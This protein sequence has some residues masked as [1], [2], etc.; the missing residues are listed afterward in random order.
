MGKRRDEG[1]GGGREGEA[2]RREA[3]NRAAARQREPSQMVLDPPGKSTSSQEA[4]VV[5]R[6]RRT[7]AL[8]PRHTATVPPHELLPRPLLFPLLTRASLAHCHPRASLHVPS[9][10]RS[11][12]GSVWKSAYGPPPLPEVPFPPP[13]SHRPRAVFPRPPRM[14]LAPSPS[15]SAPPPRRRRPT[16]APAVIMTAV[17][18]AMAARPRHGRG[19]PP[20]RRP[21][22]LVEGIVSATGTGIR[23]KGEAEQRIVKTK[24]GAQQREMCVGAGDVG[25]RGG[26]DA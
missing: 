14:K 9:F 20:A 15:P 16:T 23:L 6:T 11:P 22:G 3:A 17:T 7:R 2:D 26:E 25:M 24:R 4:T 21:K 1:S 19:R 18:A 13:P 12:E 5:L 10:I 8:P